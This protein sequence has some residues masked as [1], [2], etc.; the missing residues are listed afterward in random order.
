M[1]SCAA[2]GLICLPVTGRMNARGK[3]VL[4]WKLQSITHVSVNEKR[5]EIHTF[6]LPVP[7]ELTCTRKQA[8]QLVSR[9]DGY[10]TYPAIVVVYE[11]SGS[12]LE[13]GLEHTAEEG[14]TAVS[15]LKF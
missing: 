3:T 8:S 5:L 2:L 4:R 6:P 14:W 7:K 11:A 15:N 12:D 13:G 9:G 1:Q 10:C